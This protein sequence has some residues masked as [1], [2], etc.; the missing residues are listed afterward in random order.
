MGNNLAS[1]IYT[2]INKRAE[3]DYWDFKQEW[4]KDNERLL[5]DILCFANTVHDRDSYL[6]IGVSDDGEIIGLNE[7]NRIKQVTILDLLS[8]VVF[9]GDNTPE[10]KVETIRID[11][12]EIDILTVFNSYNVPFYLKKKSKRYHNIKEEYICI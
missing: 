1:K 6:I 5:H 2:L 11:G 10:I 4:H 8:N 12:K 3:R 7:K 9:A